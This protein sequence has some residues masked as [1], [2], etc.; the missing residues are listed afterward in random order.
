MAKR[1]LI[2]QLR[3]LGDILLTTP[4]I[5]VLRQA[6]PDAQI[7][8]CAH[9]MGRLI[10]DGNPHLNHLHTYGDDFTLK[11][12]WQFITHLRKQRYDLVF[13]FMNNPRSALFS[14][15][16]GAT[17]RLAFQSARA[18]CY[19]QTTPRP[20]DEHYIA[21]EKL[22]LV[23]AAGID[24]A[25]TPLVLPL[26]SEHHLPTTAF[27]ARHPEF[28]L[29]PLRV[30]LSPTHRRTPRQWPLERYAAIADFLAREWAAFVSWS[31]GPGE[32]HIVD[33]CIALTKT[34]TYKMPAT[35]FREMAAFIKSHDL[36]IG[37]SNGPS[38]VAVAVDICSLQ[39]HGPT[40]SSSWCPQTE[41]HQAL[42]APSQQGDISA[43]TVEMVIDKL[44]A[45]RPQIR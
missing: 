28:K 42:Q 25:T 18:W 32:E 6:L 44:T 11:Q 17:R 33:Q 35:N 20:L 8:F 45:M 4:C 2:I 24:A 13:D 38:H 41:K 3:Q 12:H 7:D 9:R 5:T 16:S 15:A 27:A 36:F 19:T 26:S 29:A 43:I 39:L 40:R 23:R 37:N 21:Q 14:I 31:W 30:V 22:K 10:L 1:I 34:A